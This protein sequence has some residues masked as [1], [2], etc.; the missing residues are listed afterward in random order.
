MG[1]QTWRRQFQTGRSSR[2][3][4]DQTSRISTRPHTP[5]LFLERTQDA[6]SSAAG[7][8]GA[9][10]GPSRGQTERDGLEHA[11][12]VRA[13]FEN[14]RGIHGNGHEMSVSAG[15]LVQVPPVEQ[16]AIHP[17]SHPGPGSRQPRPSR[18]VRHATG[19]ISSHGRTEGTGRYPGFTLQQAKLLPRQHGPRAKRAGVAEPEA[20]RRVATTFTTNSGTARLFPQRSPR[21]SPSISSTIRLDRQ[22]WSSLLSIRNKANLNTHSQTCSLLVSLAATPRPTSVFKA[23]KAA[24]PHHFHTITAALPT[25]PEQIPPPGPPLPAFPTP[26][27]KTINKSETPWLSTNS[28]VLQPFRLARHLHHPHTR[29]PAAEALLALQLVS[30]AAVARTRTA[31]TPAGSCRARGFPSRESILRHRRA[32]AVWRATCT[33]CSIRRTRRRERARM[34][35]TGEWMRGR[36]RDCSEGIESRR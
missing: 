21:S 22:C 35:V 13:G 6:S 14:R 15:R 11:G 2:P 4:R 27:N 20:I 19:H 29:F 1:V 5:R 3:P 17:H 36:G 9:N 16:R 28:R 10:A 33:T 32:G 24:H 23:G 25:P 8:Y 26:N 34:R 31:T 12:H 7:P 30:A 18:C